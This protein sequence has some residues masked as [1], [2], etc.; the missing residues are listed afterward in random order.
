MASYHGKGAMLLLIVWLLYL[1][2]CCHHITILISLSIT[3]TT[4]RAATANICTL[5]HKR[6]TWLMRLH[7]VDVALLKDHHIQ[8]RS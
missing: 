2:V 8:N 7:V 1:V 4:G 3:V 5:A 6:R